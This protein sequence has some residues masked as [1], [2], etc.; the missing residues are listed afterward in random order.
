MKSNENIEESGKSS[1]LLLG[2]RYCYCAPCDTGPQ[3]GE[4]PPGLLV[5]LNNCIMGAPFITNHAPAGS[6]SVLH[7]FLLTTRLFQT[8]YLSFF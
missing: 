1:T 6:R 4:G 2:C 8:L 7:P 5:P 3:A